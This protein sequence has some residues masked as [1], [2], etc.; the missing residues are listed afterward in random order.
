[1]VVATLKKALIS[2]EV[3]IMALFSMPKMFAMFKHTK[4]YFRL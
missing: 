3:R 1:M 2:K 4:E